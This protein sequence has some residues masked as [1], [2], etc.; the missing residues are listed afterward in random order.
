MI[1]DY[2]KFLRIIAQN[3]PYFK[4][5]RLI[6]E[7]V[8]LDKGFVRFAIEFV[9]GSELHVFEYVNADLK[10]IDYSYHFQDKDQKLIKRWDSAPHHPQI[11]T[12]PHHIHYG[13]KIKPSE[14][15]NL[16]NILKIIENELKI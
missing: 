8:T 11:K 2:F 16:V 15:P 6:K 13:E 9:D 3:N 10:K 7:L 4:D 1:E 5:F 14:E 12:F